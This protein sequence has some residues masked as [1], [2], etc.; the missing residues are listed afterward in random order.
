MVWELALESI[1]NEIADRGY[2]L[3]T[4][5]WS[6]FKEKHNIIDRGRAPY[7]LSIDFWRKQ[8]PELK[9]K[10]LYVIRL[11]DGGFVILPEDIY[12]KPYLDLSI[13]K[14]QEI[15]LETPSSFEHLKKVY[16]KIFSS[17]SS[18]ENPLL[19]TLG[20]YGVYDW[21]VKETLDID[22][23]YVGPRG[24]ER[25]KFDTYFQSKD[26][27]YLQF[28]YEG[29]V[30]LDYSIFTKNRIYVIEA[31][32]L[33]SNGG[34]D[35]GWHKLA[36]P[37]Q[38]FAALSQ[39]MGFE[40]SPAYLLRRKTKKTDIGFLFIFAPIRFH[41]GNGVV[42]NRGSDWTVEHVFSMN[43]KSLMEPSQQT[44]KNR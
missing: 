1:Q 17:R 7:H 14:P 19:E 6:D 24:N 13:K 22:D 23:F 39:E 8:R 36:F 2:F 40:V 33:K 28:E 42:L 32:S 27:F 31:K 37:T 29:Q 10:K 16:K 20:F 4:K 3:W 38:R 9:Q 35:V 25:S 5:S 11:G 34:L 26:K 15:P 21:I 18:H 30:D 43:F 12:P 41:E 44:L